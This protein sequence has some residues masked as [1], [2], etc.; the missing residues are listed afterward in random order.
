[1]RWADGSLNKDHF[2]V[3]LSKVG[4]HE[5]HLR[6]LGE[7]QILRRAKER[8]TPREYRA[9]SSELELRGVV[10]ADGRNQ[11]ASMLKQ[12]R[13]GDPRQE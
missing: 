1:L 3:L 10:T 8:L 7:L 2:R 4:M 5:F 11:A 12:F 13:R 6:Q 9:F